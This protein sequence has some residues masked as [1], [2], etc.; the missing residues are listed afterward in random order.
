MLEKYVKY[1]NN[2]YYVIFY[3]LSRMKRKSALNVSLSNELIEDLERRRGLVKM[4]NYVEHLIRRGLKEEKEP[5]GKGV[6]RL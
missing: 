3:S 4:S 1:D 6:N 5:D 2:A